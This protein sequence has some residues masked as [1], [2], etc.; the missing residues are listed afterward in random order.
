MVGILQTN[1]LKVVTNLVTSAAASTGQAPTS[2][3]LTLL[4]D[5]ILSNPEISLAIL[6]AFAAAASWVGCR[7]SLRVWSCAY[8]KVISLRFKSRFWFRRCN[9]K[10]VTIDD[11]VFLLE[12]LRSA[13]VKHFKYK[14][15]SPKIVIHAFTMQLPSD[16]PLWN[17]HVVADTVGKIGLEKYYFAFKDFLNAASTNGYSVE[18]KRVI[19]I[20]SYKSPSGEKRLEQLQR[21]VNLDY[22]NKYINTLHNSAADAFYYLTE[23]PWPR[24]LTDVV[25]YGLEIDGK[26][27]WLWAVT[28]SFNTG[29]DLILLRTHRLANRKM[30]KHLPLP[31]ELKTL[32]QLADKAGD[33]TWH[34]LTLGALKKS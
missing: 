10:I 3:K 13:I 7:Y 29:E 30:P 20:D 5:W 2:S 12:K 33:T 15:V 21:D 31:A 32:E 9:A 26:R 11:Y 22:C 6:A 4:K 23:R 17:S 18:V 28:T 16:W 19:V 24:W 27:R 14:K 8:W 1:A 34:M 25:L